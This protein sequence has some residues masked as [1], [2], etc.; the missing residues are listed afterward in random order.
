MLGLNFVN[1]GKMGKKGRLGTFDVPREEARKG[2]ELS[3]RDL[4]RSS[5]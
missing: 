1:E 3:E 5:I 4:K 2:V